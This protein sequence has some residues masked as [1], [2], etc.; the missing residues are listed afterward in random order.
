MQPLS[1]IAIEL[2]SDVQ[3]K[4]RHFF[5]HLFE[6]LDPLL[7]WKE[8]TLKAV[9]RES[10]ELVKIEIEELRG[11][12]VFVRQRR[13]AHQPVVGVQRD[14]HSGIEVVAKRMRLV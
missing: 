13:A 10:T 11:V 5:G 9:E 2:S 14:V 12:D 3:R 4:F 7:P 8:S 6:K 1:R